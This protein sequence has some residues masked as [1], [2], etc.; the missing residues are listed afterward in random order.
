MSSVK[1]DLQ[2]LSP[3]L[4]VDIDETLSWTIGYWVERL[5]KLFGNPEGLSVSEL[6]KKYRY[7]QNVPY[8]QSAEAIEWMDKHRGSNEVQEELPIIEGS[9]VFLNKISEVIPISVY[10]TI[11]PKKVISGTKSWLDKHNF[12]KAPVVCCPDEVPFEDKISGKPN[13]SKIIIP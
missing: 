4:A 6:I 1:F 2:N 7:T 3:G 9:S 10:L 12:P 5:Q 13:F 11:R 8:W